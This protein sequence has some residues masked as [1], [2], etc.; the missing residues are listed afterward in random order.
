MI[1]FSQKKRP[2]PHNEVIFRNEVVEMVNKA[3]F[4][5]VIFD[6]HLNWKDHVKIISQNISKSCCIIYQ[7]RNNL[8]VKMEETFL[9]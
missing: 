9:L 7:I 3:K 4:L 2:T 5:G 1:M 8:D 6:Q